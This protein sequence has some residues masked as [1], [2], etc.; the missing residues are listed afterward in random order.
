MTIQFT[1]YPPVNSDSS[2]K[3]LYGDIITHC[4]DWQHYANKS[5]K[6]TTAHECTH[7]I[8]ND[9]RLASGNWEGKNG[10]YLGKNRSILLDEPKMKKSAIIPYIPQELR[11]ARYNLYV[12]GQQSWDDKPL[13]IYDEGV[14]YVNGSWA[15]IELKESE[16]YV[17][18]YIPEPSRGRDTYHI[19]G[20]PETDAQDNYTS[21]LK[22][23]YKIPRTPMQFCSK[24][25]S[26]I[27][28]GPVEFIPYM[29]A[30]L[31]AADKLS[32]PLDQRLIDFSRWL[33][34]HASNSYFR[35]KKDGFPAFDVQDKLWQTMKNDACYSTQR[36]FLK[37]RVG[38]IFPDGEVPEDDV[39]PPPPW[40]I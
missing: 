36:E 2:D 9:L 33:F 24:A 14:A 20:I 8:N 37:T 15:A 27:V 12:A 10:F 38:Y 11:S 16:N 29:T 28:D 22:Q 30:V 13:Y 21:K 25:G 5:S 3:T 40:F 4:K 32:P 34:R 39:N 6:Y 26:T 35:T 17:E 18:R 1:Q 7:G 23:E 19:W 31:I